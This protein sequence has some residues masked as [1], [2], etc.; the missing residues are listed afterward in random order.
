MKRIKL[1]EAVRLIEV[2]G[3]EQRLPV[4]P[5]YFNLPLIQYYMH[6]NKL[7]DEDFAKKLRVSLDALLELLEYRRYDFTNE[8]FDRMSNVM[9]CPLEYILLNDF[10]G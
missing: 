5:Y 1:K 10:L 9:N 7:T 3:T 8:I 2:E 6:I 4:W